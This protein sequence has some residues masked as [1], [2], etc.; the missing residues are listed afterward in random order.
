MAAGLGISAAVRLLTGEGWSGFIIGVA[1]A[2]SLWVMLLFG[3]Y[4][5]RTS[6]RV[7]VQR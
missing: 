2:L 1:L 6:S 4:S 5:I 3:L 7:P